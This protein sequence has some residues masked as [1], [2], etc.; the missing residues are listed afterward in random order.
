MHFFICTVAQL[1]ASRHPPPTSTAAASSISSTWRG[2][3]S[4]PPIIHHIW[5]A[6]GTHRICTAA[7]IHPHHP[8]AQLLQLTHLPAQLQPVPS[9]RLGAASHQCLPPPTYSAGHLPP[10]T[11]YLHSCCNPLPT[12]H[13]LPITHLYSCCQLRL[14]HVALHLIAANHSSALTSGVRAL[15]Q[16]ALQ[17]ELEV[18]P[19][20]S[21]ALCPSK[22]QNEESKHVMPPP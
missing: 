17:A 10:P 8:P 1:P 2:T 15:V 16:L 7:A 14:L 12:P 11:I 19:V 18:R 9:P 4:V 21:Y 13:L 5:T 20:W 6:A 22:A 3:S